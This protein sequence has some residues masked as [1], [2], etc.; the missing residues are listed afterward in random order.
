MGKKL[1][2]VCPVPMECQ[3]TL[4]ALCSM[5]SHFFFMTDISKSIKNH[6][7]LQEQNNK[8][9]KQKTNTE[10]TRVFSSS[11]QA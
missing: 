4:D 5:N 9:K 1:E 2:V 7:L 10:R 11:V 3:Q 6:S 8:N